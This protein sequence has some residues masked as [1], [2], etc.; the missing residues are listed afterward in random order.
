M[1]RPMR[2]AGQALPPEACTALLETALRGVLSVWGDDGYP[3]GVPINHYYRP[4][5]GRIYFHGGR[6][7]HRVDAL[8]RGDKA[9]FCVFEETERAEDGWSRYF[10]SVIVF[11]R[12]QVV[13]DPALLDEVT[14]ALSRKFTRD[15]AY[16]EQEVAR[17][18]PATLVMALT[19]EH[20][21][22]K[23]VHEA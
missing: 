22:G 19:P 23:R 2:R 15:E 4:E 21:T 14:R 3:Y 13:D 10:E 6:I 16:I 17:F 9:S 20:M 18:G 11:G 7:G 8:T 5:D 12:L 1:F